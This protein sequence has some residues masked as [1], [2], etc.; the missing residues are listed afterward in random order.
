R[1]GPIGRLNQ[2]MLLQVPADL[3]YEHLIAALQAILDHHDALRLRAVGRADDGDWDLEIAGY[4]AVTAESCLCPIDASGLDEEVR[5]ACIA[6]Q[7]LAA[8]SRLAPAAGVMVQAVWF[9]A[10]EERAGRLLLM[11]H[12][13]AVDG[14]S[15]R[16]LVPDLTAAWEAI[17]EGRPPLL[18]PRGT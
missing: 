13:L 17:A 15:W 4:G 12:H 16:I 9:D 2:S 10:G 8:A 3:K 6:D 7:M 1:G 18:P 5:G 14:V 11:I